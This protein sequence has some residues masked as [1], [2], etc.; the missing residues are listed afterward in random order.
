MPT[1]FKG[2]VPH[3]QNGYNGSTYLAD[4]E[5]KL[6]SGSDAWSKKRVQE[7]PVAASQWL[8]EALQRESF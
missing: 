3:L 8:S 5:D 2:A 6:L 7:G 4:F 1:Y